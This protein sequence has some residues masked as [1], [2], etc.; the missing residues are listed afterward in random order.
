MNIGGWC[1]S[2]DL[3]KR[4]E[5]EEEQRKLEDIMSANLSS[6]LIKDYEEH[7]IHKAEEYFGK[8]FTEGKTKVVCEIICSDIGDDN[9]ITVHT[10]LYPAPK[11][12]EGGEEE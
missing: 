3:L 8:E 12:E 2:D 6:Q 4:M 5:K 7:I 9:T 1:Y 11:G 10:K